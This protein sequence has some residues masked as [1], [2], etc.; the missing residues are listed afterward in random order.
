MQAVC[1]ILAMIATLP[2]AQLFFFHI[3]LIR[4][5]NWIKSLFLQHSLY[6]LYSCFLPK[7]KNHQFSIY[8]ALYWC[9]FS[10]CSCVRCEP[11]RKAKRRRDY[12]TCFGTGIDVEQDIKRTLGISMPKGPLDITVPMEATASLYQMPYS[13]LNSLN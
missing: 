12:A 7:L 3:L 4:K 2:L 11:F 6:F 1:T 8:F 10:Y 5:V 9:F 13:K